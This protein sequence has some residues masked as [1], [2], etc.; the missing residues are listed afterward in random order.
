MRPSTHCELSTNVRSAK[1]WSAVRLPGR[2]TIC[3]SGI[4]ECSSEN[5]NKRFCR[6]EQHNLHKHDMKYVTSILTTAKTPIMSQMFQTQNPSFD[7]TSHCQTR[8]I[9]MIS[10]R[11]NLHLWYGEFS[12]I[13][14]TNH[15]KIFAPYFVRTKT[16]RSSVIGQKKKRRDSA[17]R[18]KSSDYF[19]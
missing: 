12:R 13:H 15:Q 10:G 5:F 8:T 16:K 11:Y 9:I 6:T 3:L 2:N 1:T 4:S 17:S 19:K 18:L 14:D 7:G